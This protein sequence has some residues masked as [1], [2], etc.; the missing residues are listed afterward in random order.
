LKKGDK[1]SKENYSPGPAAYST[2]SYWGGKSPSKKK[3]KEINYFS[4]LSKG[5]STGI[6]H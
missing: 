4:C 3:E 6:Y 5:P 1:T 2:V